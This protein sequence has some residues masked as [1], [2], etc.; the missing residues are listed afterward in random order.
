MVNKR[1]KEEWQSVIDK[2]YQEILDQLVIVLGDLNLSGTVIWSAI[3][4]IKK[5]NHESADLG[6]EHIKED[7]VILK[8]GKSKNGFIVITPIK[9]T[10]LKN[11]V[12]AFYQEGLILKK[13]KNDLSKDTRKNFS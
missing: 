1:S 13:D 9:L 2:K 4:V 6:I 10:N 5:I 7:L 11:R 12:I 3:E 8:D